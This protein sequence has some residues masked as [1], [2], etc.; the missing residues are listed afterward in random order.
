M[1]PSI[2][3]YRLEERL[4]GG[5]SG[6][7]YRAKDE[8]TGRIVAVKV[9]RDPR[10][11]PELQRA[12]HVRHPHLVELLEAAT[13]SAAAYVV[14]EHLEGKNLRDV[15][16]RHGPLDVPSAVAVLLPVLGALHAAHGHGLVHGDL[17]PANVF[18]QRRGQGG[19]RIQVLDLGGIAAA[20]AAEVIVGSS[21]YLSPEQ[22]AGEALDARSDVFGAAV[23]LVA[24]VTGR[25]PF[26]SANPV[27]TAYATVHHPA[28]R[29]DDPR[30]EPVLAVALA[31]PPGERFPTASLLAD[32]LAA[33]VPEATLSAG[34]LSALATP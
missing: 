12:M 7:V 19:A 25:P 31:K 26:A 17:K 18:V 28:P 10:A 16:D 4:G 32:A 22:A 6:D 14:M 3:G 21:A 5:G 33:R 24:L 30:L 20:P 11:V 23:L 15:L 8:R 2:A 13:D 9:L 1:V 29:L 27:A 34:V